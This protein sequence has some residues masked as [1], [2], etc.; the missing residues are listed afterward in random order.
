MFDDGLLLMLQDMTLVLSSRVGLSLLD[1]ESGKSVS[2]NISNKLM[3]NASEHHRRAK[4]SGVPSWKSEILQVIDF[5]IYVKSM[6]SI[7]MIVPIYFLCHHL[8]FLC[9]HT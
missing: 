2:Q 7:R 3:T 1:P 8:F 9:L 6:L 4:T 5:I